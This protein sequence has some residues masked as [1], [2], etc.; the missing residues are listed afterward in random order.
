MPNMGFLLFVVEIF[1]QLYNEYKYNHEF[2]GVKRLHIKLI[3]S[4]WIVFF[5]PA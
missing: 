1:S 3:T 5:V 4:T 2:P